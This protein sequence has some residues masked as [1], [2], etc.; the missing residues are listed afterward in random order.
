MSDEN[1]IRLTN[2]IPLSAIDIKFAEDKETGVKHLY[3]KGTAHG[4]K[5]NLKYIKIRQ[6]AARKAVRRFNAERK[7]GQIHQVWIDHAYINPSFLGNPARSQYVIGHVDDYSSSDDGADFAMDL[8]PDH[9]SQIHK[10]V[11]RRDIDGISI[12]ADVKK[13]DLYCSIDGKNMFGDECEH[14]IGQKLENG[15]RVI[16][17]VDDYR[18][19]ELTITAKQ[20]DLEGKLKFSELSGNIDSTITFSLDTYDKNGKLVKQGVKFQKDIQGESLKNTKKYDKVDINMTGTDDVDNDHADEKSEVTLDKFN[21]LVDTVITMKQSVDKS[22]SAVE[23]YFK[24]QEQKEKDELLTQKSKIVK[25][26]IVKNKEFGKDELLAL[27]LSY[28]EKLEKAIIPASEEDKNK[29]NSSFGVAQM[30]RD[31]EPKSDFVLS[32]DDIK[33]WARFKMGYKTPQA[34]KHIQAKVKARLNGEEIDVG[35][36]S[37]IAYLLGKNKE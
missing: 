26:I 30:G 22:T 16:M 1:F 32:R 18:L 31:D 12:G 9:P 33:A 11:L 14:M 37:F 34:P 7:A 2:F 20:A 19:D 8:N 24:A 10:A 15:E 29:T 13:D 27:D 4:F 36:E 3:L 6:T 21:E 28:L 5:I 25:R 35:N 17:E 23:S